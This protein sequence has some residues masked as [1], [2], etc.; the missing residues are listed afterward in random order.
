MYPQNT[1]PGDVQL[2][3]THRY[4]VGLTLVLRFSGVVS[5]MERSENA[6][7]FFCREKFHLNILLAISMPECLVANKILYCIVLYVLSLQIN[8]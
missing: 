1:S 2:T 6:H 7:Y 4:D 8:V 5:L 3:L